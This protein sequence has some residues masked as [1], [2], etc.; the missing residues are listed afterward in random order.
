MRIRHKYLKQRNDFFILSIILLTFILSSCGS[1]EKGKK[2]VDLKCEYLENP[3]GLDTRNPRLFWKM[4]DPERG[5]MQTA[6]QIQAATS[7]KL[8]ENDSA[9][10]WDSGIVKSDRS[11][12]IEYKGKP[13]QSGMEVCWRVRIWDENG[14]ASP[15]S[16]IA[17]WEMSLLKPSDWQAKWIGAPADLTTGELKYASPF[18]RKELKLT[19]KIKKA[20]AYISGLG[21][22]ELYINGAKSGDHVLSPN[23]TNFD[24]RELEKW[25]EPRIGNMNTTVLY[26]THDI[27]S[28]L[29]EGENT[30]GIILGN[31]WYQQADRPENPGCLYDSPRTIAQFE[32]EYENGLKETITSDDTWKVS[33]GPILFNGLHSGEIYDARLEQ[34]GWDKENFDDSSWKNAELVRPPTGILKA[35]TSP[36]DRVIQTIQP[37]EVSQREKGIYRFDMGQMISGWARLK[38]SGEKCTKIK[39]VF[40]EEFGPTYGQTDTYILKGEGVEIYEPRFTWHAFRYVD[41]FGSPAELTLENIEGRV[42][43]TDVSQAGTFECSN[44]LFNRILTNYRRTQ[45]GNMHGGVPSDCPHRERRGYTGDGQISAQSAIYNFDMAQFYTKW[46]GDISDGQNHKTGYVP[47]TTPYDGGGGGTPWGAAYVIIPWNMYLFYG[48]VEILRNHYSEMKHW[49]EFMKNNL[50]G[51][52]VLANQGLGEWVPPDVVEIDADYVNTC[53]YLWCC[54]L[55]TEVAQILNENNDENNFKALTEQAANDIDKKYFNPQDSMYSVGRQG[56]NVYPSGFGFAAKDNENAIF[57][58]MVGL[59]YNTNIHF[60]TGILGTPLLLEVLTEQ[61]RADLAYTLMNQRDFPSFGY[62]I[63]KGAT[64]IWET[65][66]GDVS[67]SH[68]MFGSVTQW[69]YRHLGGIVPDASNPG[70]KHTI[71]KPYP[72]NG[73]EFART[74][75]PSLYGL[76]GT[77]WNFSGDDFE[78]KVAI[79]ANTTATVYVLSADASMVNENGKKITNNKFVKFLRQEESFSVYEVASGE[80]NFISKGAKNLLRKTMLPAPVIALDNTFAFTGDTLEVLISAGV[81]G[82]KVYYTADGTEPSESSR[83]YENP[84]RISK[85]TTIKTKSVKDGFLP[86]TVQNGCIEFIDPN[87]NGLQYKYYEGKWMKLPD[88]SKQTVLKTGTVYEFGLD[89]I[90]PTKDEFALSFSGAINIEA[91]G[92]YEFF[93]QSNDGS[94]LYIDNRLVIDHDGPHGAEIEKSGKIELIKGMHPI[95]LDYFQAGGGLYLKVKFTG[96]GIKK[97]ELPAR[98]LFKK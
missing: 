57:E 7:I 49:I 74:T 91:D 23:Q 16:E 17:H 22:Y 19:G 44:P 81:D 2:V 89:K 47:N 60:D 42:V 88:L 40:T 1:E 67:H 39:L 61:D 64:T 55:M 75:Y 79:P 59:L 83:L 26:E 87:L 8:L 28:S 45:L 54:K 27:G 65:F 95:R 3:V 11:I 32:I 15:W 20:R 77:D 70:F 14:K 58:K 62:M 63:E 41:V 51:E 18:F 36:P 4:D 56:A 46:I 33:T 52:G 72:V 73:L 92:G 37:I 76:I 35:Q 30:L 66:Q 21:Y 94:K 68:P 43:N 96:P 85:T 9:D 31:G 6:Y 97:Q 34:I 82:A 38:I 24:R 80:Y 10:L 86:S 29:K 13:L 93:I 71:I 48:D 25:D 84:L 12:Q 69:F 90:I 5:A 50:N 98:Y 78:L 53:Y